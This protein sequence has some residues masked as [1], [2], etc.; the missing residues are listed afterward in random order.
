MYL[1]FLYSIM[2]KA[3]FAKS[4]ETAYLYPVPESARRQIVKDLNNWV[5]ERR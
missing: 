2:E 5:Y 4:L 3:N 1:I